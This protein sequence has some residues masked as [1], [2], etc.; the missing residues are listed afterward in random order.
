M[1]RRRTIK[2]TA[3]AVSQANGAKLRT[4]PAPEAEERSNL[5]AHA[6]RELNRVAQRPD[7]SFDKDQVA[8]NEHIL[9]MISIFA[10]EGH[11]GFSA[12]W[13]AAALNRLLKFKPLTPLLGTPDEWVHVGD[14]EAGVPVY[15]NSRYGCVFK[16]GN[17]QAYDIET[18]VYDDGQSL[19]HRGGERQLISFPYVPPLQPEVIKV[20]PETGDR[21]S[22]TAPEVVLRADGQLK[23][24]EGEDPT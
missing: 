21:P 5:I 4:T 9:K 24:S 15:Q 18:R 20:D 7:G 1:G 17:G 22:E 3:K 12:G 23:L 14:N 13:T 10:R 8:I 19:F 16:E 11:S 2:H 6:R